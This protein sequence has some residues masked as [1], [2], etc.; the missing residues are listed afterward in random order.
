M[1][2]HCPFRS[3]S[4][5]SLVKAGS[6]LA[7]GGGL[8]SVAK[9]SRAAL[10]PLMM[11]TGGLVSGQQLGEVVANQLGYFKEEGLDFN[12][13]PGGPNND[14]VATTASGRAD[15]GET[16]SSPSLMLAVSQGIPI[17]CFGVG[18]QEH[19][20]GYFSLAKNPVHTPADLRGKTV[21]TQGTGVILLRALMA[22]NGIDPKDVKIFIMAW[23][24]TPIMTGQVDVVTA[25]LANVSQLKPLG[26]DRAFLRLWDTGVRLYPNPYYATLD[27]LRDNK[28]TLE[29]FLR[30]AG[31]G[32]QYAYDNPEKAVALMVKEFPAMNEADELEAT[33]V[34]RRYTFGPATRAK[35][36]ATMDPAIWADQIAMWSQLGQFAATPPKV[37]DVM[38]VD[39]LNATQDSR[40]KIG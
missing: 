23:D 14:G 6:G 9:E 29:R 28:G 13:Q 17:K 19:A 27:T 21:G 22:K 15:V 33:Q 26:P 34:M 2:I 12:I 35:G 40:P 36:F 38:T 39:L 20:Y 5:R 18:G 3:M 1:E 37:G 30:A 8:L 11:Q 31:R 10:I 16:A 32:W 7:F 25:S 4:R 24:M